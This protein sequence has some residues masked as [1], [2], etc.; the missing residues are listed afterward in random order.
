MI[1]GTFLLFQPRQA[2]EKEDLSTQAIE[3]RKLGMSAPT[4]KITYH[5]NSLKYIL[6]DPLS[7]ESPYYY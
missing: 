3:D 1:S 5:P 2:L 7:G 4:R 6:E